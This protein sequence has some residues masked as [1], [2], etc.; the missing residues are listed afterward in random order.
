M[1]YAAEPVSVLP[2]DAQAALRQGKADAALHYSARG[3]RTFISPAQAAGVNDEAMELTHVALSADVAAPLIAAGASTVLVAEHPEEA[4]LLSALEQISARNDAPGKAPPK[5]RGRLKRTPPTIE[6]TARTAAGRDRDSRSAGRG[7]RCGSSSA[8]GDCADGGTAAGIPPP[9]ESARE[10]AERVAPAR[11][12][13]LALAAAGLVG[14]AVGAGLVLPDAESRR[15]CGEQR[16]DRPICAQPDR[17]RADERRGDRSQGH[18]RF[19]SRGEGRLGGS[20]SWSKLAGLGNAPAPDTGA[21]AAQARRAEAAAAALSQRLQQI[22]GRIGAVETQ[23]KT[24]ASLSPAATAAA[25]IVLAERVRIALAS[26]KPFASDVTALTRLGIS[27]DRCG[28]VDGRG[29]NPGAPTREAALL[30]ELPASMARSSSAKFCRLPSWTEKLIGLTSRIVTVRPVGDNGSADPA[31]LAAVRLEA[32]IAGGD[33]VRAAALVGA[34]AGAPARRASADFGADLRRSGRRQDAAI[35]KIAQ[36]AVAALGY[37]RLTEGIEAPWFA[38][39]SI[40]PSSPASPVGAVWLTDRP[41]EVSVLW[42]GYRIETSVAIAAVGV[43]GA[44][45]PLPACL[46]GGALRLRLAFGFQPVLA[47][48]APGAWFPG[49]L[50]RH[51]RDRRGAIPS[52]PGAYTGT[53]CVPPC[54]TPLTLLLEAQTAWLTGDRGRGRGRLQGD[55][56]PSPRRGCSACVGSSSRPSGAATCR[57]RAFRR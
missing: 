34:V 55:A 52:P 31:T 25:R 51:G 2:E 7:G 35:A 18:R 19:G 44:R 27:S 1:A 14:G 21:F 28:S 39:S 36:D 57:P 11:T 4:G 38:F 37:G 12:P 49:A 33:V 22:G 13:R 29:G 23:A 6:L 17:Q 32:A 16:A 54:R 48:A 56:R 3:A 40:S 15:A 9:V 46:G 30:A 43:V 8:R 26:G 53:P 41:G 42:Q 24:A 5:P 20:R 45:L 47:C 50:T 10:A